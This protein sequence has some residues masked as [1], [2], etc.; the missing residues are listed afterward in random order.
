M[1]TRMGAER[2]HFEL[3]GAARGVPTSHTSGATTG[4][5]RR[6]DDRVP[7][8]GGGLLGR[9]APMA[10]R[11]RQTQQ[12]ATVA[13]Q[14]RELIERT[15]EPATMASILG[16]LRALG[17]AEGSTVLVHSSLSSLGWVCGRGA[18]GG[19]WA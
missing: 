16:D 4:A 6:N 11:R 9:P 19:A 1:V 3:P 18:R 17:V 14:A 8:A 15:R 13:E 10:G 2:G 7:S 5:G 12:N